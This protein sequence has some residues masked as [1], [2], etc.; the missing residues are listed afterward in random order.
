MQKFIPSCMHCMAGNSGSSTCLKSPPNGHGLD[1][2]PKFG[3]GDDGG[4]DGSNGMDGGK[5]GG[6]G[7]ASTMVVVVEGRGWCG[8]LW[9]GTRDIAE[10]V[11]ARSRDTAGFMFWVVLFPDF[12]GVEVGN[13]GGIGSMVLECAL[14]SL[15]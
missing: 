3:E 14:G 1:V 2:V 15:S 5:D 9:Y 7:A 13:F 8:V 10:G 11:Q 6:G 12:W 4:G